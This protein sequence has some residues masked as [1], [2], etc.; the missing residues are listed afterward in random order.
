MNTVEIRM[1]DSEHNPCMYLSKENF[2]DNENSMLYSVLESSNNSSAGYYKG[3]A[4]IDSIF[5]EKI[6]NTK[7]DRSNRIGYVDNISIRNHKARRWIDKYNI[8]ESELLSARGIYN[9]ANKLVALYNDNTGEIYK[10]NETK[11]STNEKTN[12][13]IYELEKYVIGFVD[14]IDNHFL[15][16][17][18]AAAYVFLHNKVKISTKIIIGLLVCILIAIIVLITFKPVEHEIIHTNETKY[19]TDIITPIITQSVGEPED[20][21]AIDNNKASLNESDVWIY[22]FNHNMDVC[23]ATL[24]KTSNTEL[25][26]VIKPGHNMKLAAYIYDVNGN[27]LVSNTNISSKCALHVDKAPAGTQYEIRIVCTKFLMYIK[28][29]LTTEITSTKNDSTI[30]EST[31]TP[32]ITEIPTE[33]IKED[34]LIT[35]PIVTTID[36]LITQ[37]IVTITDELITQ[38]VVTITDELITQP[39]VEIIE[40]LITQPIVKI[41]DPTPTAIPTKDP[42]IAVKSDEELGAEY[43]N[44]NLSAIELNKD[45]FWIFNFSNKDEVLRAILNN[46]SNESRSLVVKPG[47]NTIDVFVYD[48]NGNLLHCNRNVNSRYECTLPIANQYEIRIVCIKNA[49]GQ[50]S[51]IDIK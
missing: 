47:R 30:I 27:L 12:E 35:Q 15:M 45:D 32:I 11:I 23:C 31:T 8:S 41:V 19:I 3:C 10:Y 34:E 21:F 51:E 2:N 40:P 22:E 29:Q 33:S 17:L 16:D 9:K 13:P 5:D 28:S 42:I 4:Y 6:D 48:I 43:F 36:E 25:N 24:T 39:V 26:F 38:P 20:Y 50:R 37:P 49:F 18:A 14:V 7:K 1:Y 46:S 44:M